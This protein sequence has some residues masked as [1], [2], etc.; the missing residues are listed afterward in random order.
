M[1][2]FTPND[3]DLFLYYKHPVNEMPTVPAEVNNCESQQN[4]STSA[5]IKKEGKKNNTCDFK[6]FT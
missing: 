2:Y 4:L 5:A 3:P 6:R 1:S